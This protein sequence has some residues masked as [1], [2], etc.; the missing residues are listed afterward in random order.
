[1]FDW[2]KDAVPVEWNED[3]RL[4]EYDLKGV[5]HVVCSQNINSTGEVKAFIAHLSCV[6]NICIY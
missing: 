5:S 3:I 1:M 6:R 4:P 2:R